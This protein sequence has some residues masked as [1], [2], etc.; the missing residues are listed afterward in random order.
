MRQG[1]K[2]PQPV[3]CEDGGEHGRIHDEQLSTAARLEMDHPTPA[4][5]AGDPRDSG[6]IQTFAGITMQTMFATACFKTE[7]KHCAGD[8]K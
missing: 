3:A 2:Y 7:W 6:R 8:M 4:R 1:I 5:P